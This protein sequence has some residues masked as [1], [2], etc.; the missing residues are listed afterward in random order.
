MNTRTTH[1]RMTTQETKA[2]NTRHTKPTTRHASGVTRHRSPFSLILLP[3]FALLLAGT[4]QAATKDWVGGTGVNM[5]TAANWSP[6]NVPGTAD[7]ARWNA[8]SYDN[9]PTMNTAL[10]IGQL[11]FGEGNSSSVTIGGSSKLTLNRI[12]GVGIQMTNGAVTINATITV[13]NNC[14]QTFINNNPSGSGALTFGGTLNVPRSR[15][16]VSGSGDTIIGTL[17]GNDGV[18]YSYFTMNGTGKL[19]LGGS[20]GNTTFLEMIANSGTMLLGKSTGNAI[21]YQ[22][23]SGQSTK[24]TIG[25]GNATPA[26]VQYTGDSTDMIAN[27]VVVT[28][29]GAGQLDFNG[30][31]DTITT[32]LTINSAGASG[33]STPITN[34]G[35]G[36]TL[37][38]GG[39][40]IT[41]RLGYNTTINSGTGTNKLTGTI[42]FNPAGSGTARISGNLH[43][44]GVNA[45]H[46]IIDG[47]AE[48]DMVIDAVISGASLGF[49]RNSDNAS[50]LVLGGSNDITG[51]VNINRGILTITNSHALGTAS[52]VTVNNGGTSTLELQ[53]NIAVGALPLTLKS[54]GPFSFGALR[55]V[56][57]NNSWGG[58]ITLVEA[59]RTINSE[60]GTLTLQGAIS[61]ATLGL[62]IGGAGNTTITNVIGTTSGTLTKNG[63]GTLTLSG[64]NTFTGSTTVNDG[65][66][67][68]DY[69]T[70]DNSKLSDTAALTLSKGTLTLSGGSHT[71]TNSATTLNTGSFVVNRSSGSS[72]LRMNAI[73][74]TAPGTIDFSA[75]GIADTD[76]ANVNGILGVGYATVGGNTWAYNSTAGSDGPIN[77]LPLGSYIA[78]AAGSLGAT[79]DNSDMSGGVDTSVAGGTINSIRFNNTAARTIT[80]S[81]GTLTVTS[82]GI[83]NTAGVGGNTTTING[84]GT[85]SAGSADLKIHQYDSGT[86]QIDAIVG[87]SGGLTKTGPGK[88]ILGGT[89]ANTQ[90]GAT[91]VN[92]GMLELNK[93]ANVK[94]LGNADIYINQNGVIKYTGTSTDM[95]GQ[96]STRIYI[97][98]NG[99]LDFN[100]ATD[101]IAN[102]PITIDSSGASGDT[103]PITNSTPASGNLTVSGFSITPLSGYNTLIQTGSGGTITLAGNVTFTAAGNGTARINGNLALS[104]SRDIS[105]ANG[106]AY[107]DMVIDA[108]I[109]GGAG[110]GIANK[111]GT[112][113]LVLSGNNTFDGPVTVANGF[114]TI[115]HGNALGSAVGGTTVNSAYTLE[116]LGNIAVGAE[117]LTL[118]SVGVT[119]GSAVGGL[120]N[121]SGDNTWGGPVTLGAASRINSDS[122]TLLIANTL[123]LAT[124]GLTVGSY[125]NVTLSGVISGTTGSTLTKDGL[126]TL[127]LSGASANTFP[128]LTTVKEGTLVLAKTAG[129][130]VSGLTVTG[131]DTYNGAYGLVRY[132]ANSANNQISGTVTLNANAQGA[133]QLD[134]NGSTDTVAVVTINSTTAI[135]NSRP[136]V[137]TGNGGQLTINSLTIV[138]GA[139]AADRFITTLDS[140]SGTFKMGG[141]VTCTAGASYGQAVIAGALDLGGATRTFNVG[142]GNAQ[143]YDL[144][145]SA[146]IAN[147][148]LTKTGTGRLYLSGANTYAGDTLVSAGTL[149]VAAT[150]SILNSPNVTVATNATLQ[151]DN[152][153]ALGANARLALVSLPGPVYG[154]ANLNFS[155]TQTVA[156]VRFD[157]VLQAKGTY[158]SNSST[159]ANKND[160]WFQG[161]GVL[162]MVPP[163]SG[164]LILMR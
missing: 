33:D 109:S 126:G 93:T 22:L 88:L 154:K 121:V 101:T 75:D 61:G 100:G 68:L 27:G 62:T 129:V 34:S 7:I 113:R 63:G 108:V 48:N 125:G 161:T 142:L 21:P 96:T 92:G 123:N 2:M 83:L 71:E 18:P 160:N 155:G 127:T 66:L 144:G 81:S 53:G 122:G 52:G 86:L 107:N 143:I 148:A 152:A 78:N 56:S 91:Y 140:G 151:L 28:I 164:T 39:L 135:A 69:S 145:I 158:G 17:T 114:L 51:P 32:A 84:A 6:A 10:T 104:A 89:T 19:T 118:S 41:P 87:G 120:R 29:Y 59:A 82:G 73:T 36:G 102:G 42:T 134:F 130:A 163:P 23:T 150:G 60:K 67:V 15:L 14:S 138:P 40:T 50:R 132:A 37:T 90:S 133:G 157:G 124:F 137:N 47:E 116:L 131:S 30:K 9:Q 99:Q 76:T 106:D 20:A 159:A 146:A 26:I 58:P 46:A 98:E 85:I 8:A 110:V 149:I 74:R 4:A 111:S 70:Q 3:L 55:N 115:A 13:N 44:N 105:V 5:G 31:S 65:T 119:V 112:G 43:L 103:C 49:T 147:G 136:I 79:T 64:A 128:T 153:N 54:V 141:T 16:T 139:V 72:V 12:E 35:S 25:Q 117:T 1:T 57:G 97:N 95:I 45:N 156:A 94:A 162:N 38:S 77:G 11:L 80:I 24:L